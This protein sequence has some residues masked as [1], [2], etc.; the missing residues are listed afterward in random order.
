MDDFSNS[1]RLK[2]IEYGVYD[3]PI[4]LEATLEPQRAFFHETLLAA[5]RRLREFAH[6]NSWHAHLSEPFARRYQAYAH[7]GAF[8]HDLLQICGLDPSMELPRTYCAAL[9]EG[10]LLSVS[11]ELY[12]EIYPEGDEEFAFEKL[13]T[14]EMAHRLH[15]RILGGDED[16]MGPIWFYEGFAL[17]AAG[18]FAQGAPSLEAD[19]IWEIVADE[20][21]GDYRRYAALFRHF[22][23]KAPLQE[24]VDRAGKEGFETWLRTISSLSLREVVP[25]DLPVFFEQQLDPGANDMAAFT[26]KD[27][28]DREAFDAHWGRILADPTILV[29]TILLDGQ[30]AGSVLSYEDEGRPEVSYWLGR[31]FWGKGI[32]TW[33]LRAFLAHHNLE[34]PI[35]ARVAKDNLGSR[36]VLEKCGFEVIEESRGFA[37]ARGM[38]IDEY[39]C[40]KGRRN[41]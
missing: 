31:E 2:S 4:Q 17:H 40:K 18:Q 13:L 6:Q 9:E 39:L 32:A 23:N 36:R 37:N 33:A 8:D 3:L 30:V 19:E 24:L 35:Y 10:V 26:A 11:P 29:R 41:R 38:E 25:D 20:E 1:T 5:Q 28:S 7:K 12:R 21:R 34:R 15:I 22:L 14:H 16:A 27:P